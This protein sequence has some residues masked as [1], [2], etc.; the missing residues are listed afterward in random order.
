MK[1]SIFAVVI[2]LIGNTGFANTTCDDLWLARNTIFD[3]NGYC[4]GS[5]LGKSIFDNNE[6]T[7]VDPKLT[8]ELETRIQKLWQR[9]KKLSCDTDQGRTSISIYNIEQRKV[10]L[11]Q[12]IASETESAC[13]GYKGLPFYLYDSPDA[14]A[15]KI[16]TIEQG[17]DIGWFHDDENTWSLMT[18]L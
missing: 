6:C 12:P 8:P 9:A 4:F 18:L 3:L 17:D 7:T 5:T 14:N 13:I 2:M 10:L 15:V 16:G 11:H 1:L